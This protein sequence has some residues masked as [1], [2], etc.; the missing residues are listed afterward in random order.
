MKKFF[1]WFTILSISILALVSCTLTPLLY[2][3]VQKDNLERGEVVKV[4]FV[5]FLF[6]P[7]YYSVSVSAGDEFER[8]DSSKGAWYL[9]SG[10]SHTM[11]V[12]TNEVSKSIS[13]GSYIYEKE[14]ML[15]EVVGDW[16]SSI[17]NWWLGKHSSYALSSTPVVVLW[18]ERGTSPYNA[19]Y[20]FYESEGVFADGIEVGDT[21]EIETRRDEHTTSYDVDIYWEKDGNDYQWWASISS[22]AP[23]RIAIE[24]DKYI[25][26][27]F[28]KVGPGKYKVVEYRELSGSEPY[29]L[30]ENLVDEINGIAVFV[31]SESSAPQKITITGPEILGAEVVM[32]LD[33]FD[34]I[35]K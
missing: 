12:T 19:R 26:V 33:T 10:F 29:Y 5:P 31:Q 23:S 18:Y 1:I 2:I 4:D 30:G 17:G 14:E 7:S 9:G 21:S 3:H 13:I 20:L 25:F 15:V 28:E 34:Y 16:D 35:S 8:L 27:R 32:P 22:S 24:G 6:S 11:S